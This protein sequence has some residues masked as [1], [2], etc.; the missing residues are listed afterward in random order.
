MEGLHTETNEICIVY[1]NLK[2]EVYIRPKQMFFEK[3]NI[4]S[5]NKV[6]RFKP[7]TYPLLILLRIPLIGKSLAKYFVKTDN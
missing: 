1:R 3:V 4:N 5:I 6:P 2:G 7:I